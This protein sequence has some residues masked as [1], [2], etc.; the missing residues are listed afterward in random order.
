VKMRI[1]PTLRPTRPR[2]I[3]FSI[4]AYDWAG[5]MLYH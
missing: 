4:P 3:V 5:L 2:L 1:I